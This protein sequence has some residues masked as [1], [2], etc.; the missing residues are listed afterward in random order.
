MEVALS[1]EVSETVI[2]A[3]FEHLVNTHSLGHDGFH[4]RDHWLR[5]LQNGRE[6]AA[7]TGANL[8]VVELF[9]VLHDSQRKNEDHDPE[10]GHRA[11]AYAQSLRGTWFDVEDGEMELL[12]EAC[13][14]HSDGF[15]DA[16]RVSP[17]FTHFPIPLNAAYQSFSTNVPSTYRCTI[18]VS[19]VW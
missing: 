3:F 5:V 13:R 1:F 6:I 16:D 4:G 15:I 10:H 14:Y 18:E 11:A 8:R 9:A 12:L 17:D 2:Q 7:E 19:N